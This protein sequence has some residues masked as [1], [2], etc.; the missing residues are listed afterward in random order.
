MINDDINLIFSP[1][2]TTVPDKM[3]LGRHLLELSKKR[4]VQN[5]SIESLD[6]VTRFQVSTVSN[7]KVM[8]RL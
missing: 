5:N 2:K 4:L 3:P 1:Q 6:Q 7:S 8:V